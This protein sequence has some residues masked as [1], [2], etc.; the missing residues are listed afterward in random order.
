VPIPHQGGEFEPHSWRGVLDTTLCD[1]VTQWLATG[2][3]FSEGTPVS[4]TNKTD[5]HDKTEMLL[6]V[7]L[8][9][10]TLYFFPLT[11]NVS[12]WLLLNANS[13]I[14]QLYNVWSKFI[15]MRWWWGPLCTRPHSE[16]T[17]LSRNLLI[18]A[19]LAEKQQLPIL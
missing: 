10:I 7:A 6:K 17:S 3:W 14:F 12:E 11:Q 4:T 2:R 15:F 19:C 9:T 8:S 13:A 18:A 1:K 5:R 16:Q